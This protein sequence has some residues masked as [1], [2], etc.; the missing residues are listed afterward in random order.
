MIDHPYRPVVRAIALDPRDHVVRRLETTQNAHGGTLTH[1]LEP[2][3][4]AQP[5]YLLV[6]HV[7]S[8]NP[9]R[10]GIPRPL[11][12]EDRHPRNRLGLATFTSVAKAVQETGTVGP[13]R[14]DVGYPFSVRRSSWTRDARGS[15]HIG[16]LLRRCGPMRGR[17]LW[18][19]VRYRSDLPPVLTKP[20][21]EQGAIRG[22][23]KRRRGQ[24]LSQFTH[25]LGIAG[26]RKHGQEANQRRCF[27]RIPDARVRDQSRYHGASAGGG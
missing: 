26:G 4:K 1:P 18:L 6:G 2:P 16:R 21:P 8:D 7:R 5:A 17:S 27:H 12:S 23:L 10:A 22:Q 20:V 3:G 19:G 25:R 11:K 13:F 14:I 9:Q 15:V 24:K